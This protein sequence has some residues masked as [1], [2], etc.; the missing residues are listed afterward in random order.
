VSLRIRTRDDNKQ[1]ALG[2]TQFESVQGAVS[3][4]LFKG[5]KVVRIT[6]VRGIEG[7]KAQMAEL[8]AEGLDAFIAHLQELRKELP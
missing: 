6:T 4:Q 1:L 2:E 5:Y 3:T 7:R 8:D